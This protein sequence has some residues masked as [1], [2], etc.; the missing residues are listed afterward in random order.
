MQ[1][2]I[3]DKCGDNERSWYCKLEHHQTA[4]KKILFGRFV[5]RCS[6]QNVNNPERGQ[7]KC[8]IQAGKYTYKNSEQYSNAKRLEAEKEPD[9]DVLSG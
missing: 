4:L 1:L 2:L 9:S 6:F 7:E 5:T 8:R 3:D